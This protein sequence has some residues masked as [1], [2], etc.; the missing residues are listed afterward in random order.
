MKLKKILTA[1][2]TSALVLSF[3]GCGGNNAATTTTAAPAET[4]TTAA[5]AADKETKADDTTAAPAE[6]TAAPETEAAPTGEKLTLRV[7]T[8]RTDRVQDGHLDEITA[9]FEEANNCDV[10]YQGYTDYVSDV[11]TMMNTTDYGDVLFIPDTVKLSDLANFFEPLGTYDEID[12]VYNWADAK[13]YDGVVYGIAHRGNVSGGICYNKKVWAAAGVTELPTTP[14]A[15]IEDLKLIRDNTDAIPYYTNFAAAD[16]TLVQ[17]AA[18]VLSA[19][20]S[21]S[22]ENDLLINKEDIFTPGGAYYNV[23]KL[24]YDVF[25]DPSLIEEDPATTDWEGCKGAINNGLIGTMV[26]GSW[27]V[28]QFAEAG[29]NPDDIGYMPAPFSIGG[30]QYAQSAPDYCFGIN[31]NISDDVKELGKKYIK[32]YIEESGD[33]EA[34]G[35]I[36]TLKGSKMPDYLEAFQ[37]CVLFTAAPAPDG[38]VGVFDAINNDSQVGTWAGDAANFKIRIAEAAIGGQDFSAV[39]AIFADNN[40]RWAATRDANAELAAYLAG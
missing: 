10:I 21:P 17:W 13:M 12:S 30:Q 22:Y 35:S 7:L 23:Y 19:S 36:G 1:A 28:S 5:P 24:M 32:W 27:A 6:T 37:N 3:A 26:M 11:S 8:C 33:A 4:T 20:G 25:S 31:K 16:W 18:L 9:A 2:L 40:A 39:E 14:E 34:E 38:L 29:P 15:F